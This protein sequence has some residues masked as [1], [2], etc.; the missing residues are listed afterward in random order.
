MLEHDDEED[1]NEEGETSSTPEDKSD[2][3]ASL[4]A[5]GFPSDLVGMVLEERSRQVEFSMDEL[6]ERLRDLQVWLFRHCG[7]RGL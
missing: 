2:V 1:T 5:M 4:L 6:I 3:A 7:R